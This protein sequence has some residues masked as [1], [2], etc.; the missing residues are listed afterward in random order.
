MA[1]VDLYDEHILRQIAIDHYERNRAQH[2]IAKSLGVSRPS[3]TEALKRAR[4]LGIVKITI[5]RDKEREPSLSRLQTAMLRKFDI[6]KDVE[7]VVGNIDVEGSLAPNVIPDIAKAA[8]TY[9][10]GQLIK[11]KDEE[12]TRLAVSGGRQFIRQ[13]VQSLSPNTKL[14]NLEVYPISGFIREQ[15]NNG[16]ASVLAYD[17]ATLYEAKY[18][19]LPVPAIVNTA[20][21]CELAK[22]LPIVRDVLDR[23]KKADFYLITLFPLYYDDMEMIIRRGVLQKEQLRKISQNA[24]CNIEMW[25]YTAKGECVNTKISEPPFYLTGYDINNLREKVEKGQEEVILVTG[26]KGTE[27]DQGTAERQRK[28]G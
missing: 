12:R 25:F 23:V 9:L 4:A 14:S 24:V 19:W 20:E 6:L 8:A 3:I 27:K 10:E 15:A 13:V 21:Q 16:D 7:L 5:P 11:R 1:K 17:I 22:E 18:A 2:D 28:E 26:G